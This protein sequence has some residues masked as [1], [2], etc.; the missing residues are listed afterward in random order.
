MP[1]SGDKVLQPLHSPLSFQCTPQAI[2]RGIFLK[3]NLCFLKHVTCPLESQM[4]KLQLDL[5]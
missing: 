1:D 3:K 4:M 5:T 2:L